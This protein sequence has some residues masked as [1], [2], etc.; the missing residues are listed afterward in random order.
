MTDPDG[1]V[2]A[3]IF[4]SGLPCNAK[5]SHPV[6]HGSWSGPSREPN[7]EYVPLERRDGP[8][9]RAS[10]LRVLAHIRTAL[11]YLDVMV[12]RQT[13]TGATSAR[14][15]LLAALSEGED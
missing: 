14:S 4:D 1:G 9:R 11:S 8:Q 13:L 10:D 2:C 15:N 3:V 6:H 7:H 5:A 12:E